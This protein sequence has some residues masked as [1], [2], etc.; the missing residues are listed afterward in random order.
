MRIGPGGHANRDHVMSASTATCVV[1]GRD[2]GYS[3]PRTDPG[4]RCPSLPL[5]LG[6]AV[7]SFSSSA[8]E[9]FAEPF[10]RFVQFEGTTVVM[11]LLVPQVKLSKRLE[12][13]RAAERWSGQLL[14]LIEQQLSRG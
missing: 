1:R 8:L 4:V 10:G 14:V 11:F 12:V 9:C 6:D 7:G 2:G 13:A 3:P 5:H